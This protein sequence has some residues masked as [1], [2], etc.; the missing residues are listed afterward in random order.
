M[1]KRIARYL[2]GGLAAFLVTV[3][4]LDQP[5]S[6]QSRVADPNLRRD[7]ENAFGRDYRLRDS[8]IL[9]RASSGVVTLRGTLP[10]LLDS[11]AAEMIARRTNGVHAVTNFIVVE[12]IP[13][14]DPKILEAIQ[15]RLAHNKWLNLPGIKVSVANGI[16]TLA[17]EVEADSVLQAERI[18]REVRGVRSIKNELRVIAPP[19]VIP[20]EQVLADIESTFEHDA[21]LF[22]FRLE[23]DVDAGVVTLDGK[24]PSLFLKE[25]AA[26]QARLVTGVRSVHN[27]VVT[28]VELMLDMVATPISDSEMLLLVKR[29]LAADPRVNVEGIDPQ[30][31]QG[32]VVLRGTVESLYSKLL[33]GRIARQLVG[34]RWLKNELAVQTD[35]GSEQSMRAEVESLL[36]SDASLAGEA[37]GVSVHEGQVTLTGQVSAYPARIRAANLASRVAGVR[38]IANEM[39]VVVKQARS[40]E[41]IQEDIVQGLAASSITRGRVDGVRINVRDAVVIL[42]GEVDRYVTVLEVYRVANRTD[43]VRQ[44]ENLLTVKAD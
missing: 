23:V 42:E 41:S 21:Y 39:Q 4:M 17:G 14:D 26:N 35:S 6:S 12:P 1:M 15:Q 30:V 13:S 10:S 44:V 19:T 9:V 7:V 29:E 31:M 2:V 8:N 24:V 40:D 25:R 38:S 37:I 33:A 5:G 11:H 16:V 28:D 18:A 22:A 36:E 3:L 34:V 32:E 27:A 20:D 43:G